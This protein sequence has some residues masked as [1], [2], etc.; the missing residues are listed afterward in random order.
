VSQRRRYHDVVATLK[1]R[2]FVYQTTAFTHESDPSDASAGGAAKGSVYVGFDPTAE[3]LH[4]GNLLGLLALLHFQ[5]A[6]HRPIALV[7]GATG[8]IGDP[9]GR[10][11]E[12]S[13][14]DEATLERNVR[15][16]ESCLRLL[17]TE[18]GPAFKIVNNFD[19]YRDMNVLSF[20][21]DVGKHFRLGTMLSK[22]SVRSRMERDDNAGMSF[23]EFSYQALQGYDFLNLYRTEGCRLQLGGS[24]QWGNI[25]AGC[26]LI[27]KVEG[28][29]AHGV[30]I[31]LLTTST[32][33]KVGKSAGNAAVWLCP[34]RTSHYEFYQYF[35]NTRDADIRRFLKLFTLLPLSQIEEIAHAHDQRPE[36]HSGQNVLAAEI[37]RL[38]RGEH[39]LR[40]ALKAT[41]VMFGDEPVD[42]LPP[43]ELLAVMK[44]VPSVTLPRSAVVGQPLVGIMVACRVTTSK[45][46]ARRLVKGGGVYVNSKRVPSDDYQLAPEDVLGDSLCVL[47]VGKKSYFLVKTTTPH[48]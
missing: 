39:G 45:G 8:R 27:R 38:V 18:G 46:E 4:V 29:E 22:E 30:T 12:R 3:S 15:G 7:G 48:C 6:G 36:E 10:A 31:P 2:G 5:R 40:T 28:V 13:L 20:L 35:R 9:S 17:D 42:S 41:G 26:D 1:E 34:T 23:T 19:W 43:S 47:R 25:T 14:L 32:G 21:R 16:I 24:D 37:T 11:T 44:D 33:E